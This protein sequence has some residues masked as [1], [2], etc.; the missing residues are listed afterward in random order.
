MNEITNY[1]DLLVHKNL[2]IGNRYLFEGEIM[3]INTYFRANLEQIMINN[4]FSDNEYISFGLTKLE[5][6]IREGDKK[7]IFHKNELLCIPENFLCKI[8]SLSDII[9]EY[10]LCDNIFLEDM[11]QEIDRYF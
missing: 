6:I 8:Q 10:K 5:Q 9:N 1:I 7:I 3:G 4:S 11:L 2:I